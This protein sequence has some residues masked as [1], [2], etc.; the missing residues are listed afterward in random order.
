MSV[1]ADAL[2]RF[3]AANRRASIAL[4]KRFPGHFTQPRTY[5]KV[6]LERTHSDLRGGMRSI[7][8]AGGIDR[9]LL[10]RSE[11]YTYHGLDIEEQERCH[12][13]YDRFWVQ[14]IEEPVPGRY[15]IIFSVTLLEHVRNNEAAIASIY[16]SLEPGGITY[17]YVPSMG[18]PYALILRLVGPVWQ[19]RLIGTLRTQEEASVSGYATFFDHCTSRQMRRLF[20]AASFEQVK[21]RLFY[22][23]NGYFQFF[24]PLFVL[25]SVFENLCARLGWSYFASGF[26]ISGRRPQAAPGAPEAS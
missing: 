11:G 21:V 6:L 22:R 4:A 13:V 15:E 26:I 3:I 8:E 2:R 23:A 7:L 17:H 19:K 10:P 5:R 1:V 20:E 14:S 18:H 24:T 25:V 12:E 9:P 16:E